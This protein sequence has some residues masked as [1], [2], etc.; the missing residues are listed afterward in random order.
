MSEKL[1]TRSELYDYYR[2]SVPGTSD[3]K[4][5]KRTICDGVLL[6]ENRIALVLAQ[7][8]F[9][10]NVQLIFFPVRI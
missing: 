4:G 1:Y 5:P 10:C 6:K 8:I 7:Y 9:A 3:E 2:V